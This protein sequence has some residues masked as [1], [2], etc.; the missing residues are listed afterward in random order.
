MTRAA[1]EID[2]STPSEPRSD[3]PDAD[4]PVEALAARLDHIR[5]DARRDPEGYLRRTLVP[6]GGE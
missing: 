1:K 2:T 5:Q 4:Q 3:A 6:E